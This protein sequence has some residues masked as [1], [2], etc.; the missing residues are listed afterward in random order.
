MKKDIICQCGHDKRFHNKVGAPI[1]DEWCNGGRIRD[2]KV[3]NYVF[4]CTCFTYQPDNLLHIETVAKK[5]G[6]I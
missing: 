6:L 5:K 1:W 4:V 2:R 3:G